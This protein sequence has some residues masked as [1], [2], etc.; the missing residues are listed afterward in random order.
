MQV[1]NLQ[2]DRWR[3]VST[4]T[5]SMG[6]CDKKERGGNKGEYLYTGSSTGRMYRKVYKAEKQYIGRNHVTELASKHSLTPQTI[7]REGSRD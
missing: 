6:N 1:G 2:Q 3:R 7:Q 4:A 5:L